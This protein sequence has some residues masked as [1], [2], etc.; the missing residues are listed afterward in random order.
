LHEA[1]P[2][3][4]K[5]GRTTIDQYN[6]SCRSNTTH[7]LVCKNKA[8]SYLEKEQYKKIQVNTIISLLQVKFKNER[9]HIF[10]FYT[11]EPFL[12]RTNNIQL[13]LPFRKP[14]CSLESSLERIGLSQ[15]SLALAII[16]YAKLHSTIGLKSQKVV[17]L[18][19]F[20][21]REKNVVFKDLSIVP[22]LLDSSTASSRSSPTISNKW[23]KNSTV[24]PFGS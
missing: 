3:L 6:V 23:R 12:R 2:T 21:M 15:F 8:K 11:V 18:L 22:S 16:L 20:R 24:H 10:H 7:N 9:L 19:T 5:R 14:S 17:G 1:T 4:E 13:C